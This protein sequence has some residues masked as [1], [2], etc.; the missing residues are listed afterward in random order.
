MKALYVSSLVATIVMFIAVG[1]VATEYSEKSWDL[2]FSSLYSDYSYGYDYSAYDELDSINMK[3]G[4]ISMLFCVFYILTFSFTIK[5]VK[6]TTAKVMSIIGLSVSGLIFLCCLVPISGEGDFDEF[7]AVMY[8]YGL[9]M[10]A[11]CIVNLVQSVRAG[12]KTPNTSS[13]II[14]DVM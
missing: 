3:G 11:F 2:I 9:I 8:L 13:A 1:I 10:L 6:T 12:A 5:N 14:D 7:A 4:A